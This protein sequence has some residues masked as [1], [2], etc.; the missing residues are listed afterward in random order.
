MADKRRSSEREPHRVSAG[1]GQKAIELAA[2]VGK[3]KQDLMDAANL[4]LST[5]NRLIR[6]DGS[7]LSAIQIKNVLRSWGADVSSLPPVDADDD[8]PEPMDEKLREAIELVRKIWEVASEKRFQVVIDDVHD[9]IRA[10]EIVAR[11]TGEI[12]RKKP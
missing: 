12:G 8:G 11:G 1:F 3:T 10:H 4:S 6:G 5:I 2:S 9:V 7:P